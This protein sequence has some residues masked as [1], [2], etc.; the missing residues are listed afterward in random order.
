MLSTEVLFPFLA[1]L[2]S[3]NRISATGKANQSCVAS[4]TNGILPAFFFLMRKSQE[5]E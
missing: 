1:Y 4:F 3:A 2:S 5:K